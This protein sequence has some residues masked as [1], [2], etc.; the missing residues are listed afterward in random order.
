[1]RRGLYAIVDV[2]QCL[3]RALSPL[4]TA[5]AILTANPPY[6]QLRAK[7]SS[8]RQMLELLKALRQ[9]VP[10]AT[11][12]FANDRPDLADLAAC[13]G[14][15]LGQQDLSPLLAR[16]FAPKLQLGLSTHNWREL[17]VVLKLRP[18]YV[19]FGPVFETSSK[20]NPD[21][22]VGLQRLAQARARCLQAGIPLV[23]IGGISAKTAA[24][25][26]T[27]ADWGAVISGLLPEPDSAAPY[28]QISEKAKELQRLLS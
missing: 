19:A 21:P 26:S 1:M 23:A 2:D 7:S 11:R 4:E 8:P 16:R 14:V 3:A 9:S 6:L 13:D 24:S 27:Q 10:G 5:Q 22:V 20:V 18:E 17:D 25:V 12:L 15:H 28:R